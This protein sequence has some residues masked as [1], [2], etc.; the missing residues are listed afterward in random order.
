MSGDLSVYGLQAKPS[1]LTLL[2]P[3]AN[4]LQ[5]WEIEQTQTCGTSV[6]EGQ[7]VA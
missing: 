6:G 5:G 2:E 4:G 3:W 7:Q 1:G